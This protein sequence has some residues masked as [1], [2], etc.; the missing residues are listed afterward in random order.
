MSSFL[1]GTGRKEPYVM[2]TGNSYVS[3]EIAWL[4]EDTFCPL[5]GFSCAKHF[6]FYLI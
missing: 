1:A 5:L 6:Y 4:Q 2:K 3:K